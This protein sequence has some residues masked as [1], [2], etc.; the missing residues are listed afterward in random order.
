MD[1]IIHEGQSYEFNP[2]VCVCGEPLK[3]KTC[4]IL[5]R[6]HVDC[7]KCGFSLEAHPTREKGVFQTIRVTPG[8]F[9]PKT[10][11]K[12]AGMK[13]WL[14]KLVCKFRQN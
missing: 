12:L 3:R 1:T 14:Q 8:V 10:S 11:G 9:V 4:A 13:A 6:E 7:Q 2:H 5:L